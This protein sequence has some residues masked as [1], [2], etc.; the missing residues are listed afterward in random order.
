MHLH[1]E[2]QFNHQGP[3]TRTSLASA[4]HQCYLRHPLATSHI[5]EVT[6]KV[7][8]HSTPAMPIR[9]LEK[10]LFVAGKRQAVEEGRLDMKMSPSEHVCTWIVKLP[11]CIPL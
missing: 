1:F 3:S 6:R 9:V 8:N 11:R 5:S 2:H 7:Q 10:E 4:R